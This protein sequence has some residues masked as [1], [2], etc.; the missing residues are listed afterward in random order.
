MENLV[1]PDSPELM[2]QR[3]KKETPEGQDLK[4]LEVHQEFKVS[5]NDTHEA[6]CNMSDVERLRSN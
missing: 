2:D 4:G 5:L 1:L 3:E 6:K